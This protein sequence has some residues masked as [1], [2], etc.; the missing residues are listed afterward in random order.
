[1]KLNV[2]AIYDTA[3]GAYMRPFFLTADGQARRMFGDMA[4]DENHEIGKH[5]E[6]YHLVRIGVFD[7]QDASWA[8]E[9]AETLMTG[10]EAVSAHQ[11]RQIDFIG[12]NGDGPISDAT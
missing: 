7:D 11:N 3:V 1:M 8:Q 2:Y 4:N 10:L 6:H 12:G 9:R 5:P